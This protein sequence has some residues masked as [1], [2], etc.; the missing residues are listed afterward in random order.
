[1]AV[2]N[3]EG[4]E[5]SQSG[6]QA[7]GE[8]GQGGDA[9]AQAAAAE[10]ARIAAGGESPEAKAARET[11]EAAEAKGKE[12]F[13]GDKGTLKV[14][15]GS[16]LALGRLDKILADAKAKGLTVSETQALVDSEH[17]TVSA[18]VESEKARHKVTADGWANEVKSHP[19]LGGA[20]YE[21]TLA[22]SH[23]AIEKFAPKGFKEILSSTGLGNHPLLV[24]FAYNIGAA[25][26]DDKFV[27]AGSEGAKEEKT[28]GELFTGKKPGELFKS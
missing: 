20:K 17:G 15:D 6:S 4:G 27:N 18:F 9:A 14:P 5:K 12:K 3:Q 22:V 26:K 7:G 11:K 13:G 10:A 1:M 2:E 8:G 28:L 24:E 21:E 23:D 16:P 25:M 19:T